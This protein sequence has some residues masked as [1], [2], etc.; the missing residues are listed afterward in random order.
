MMIDADTA[1]ISDVFYAAAE[2]DS[3]LC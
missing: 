2:I 3:L 1:V